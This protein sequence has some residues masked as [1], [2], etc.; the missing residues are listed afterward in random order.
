VYADFCDRPKLG[1][2]FLVF[3]E[4]VH[5]LSNGRLA[6]GFVEEARNQGWFKSMVRNMTTAVRASTSAGSW[7]SFD[8]FHGLGNGILLQDLR[9]IITEAG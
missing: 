9:G 1:C 6:E 5:G 2:G 7:A 8:S 3:R 4:T